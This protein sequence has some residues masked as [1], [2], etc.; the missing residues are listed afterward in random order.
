ML[1]P[2]FRG[3]KG[4]H[5]TPDYRGAPF[6]FAP[7]GR[8]PMSLFFALA[9]FAHWLWCVWLE[10]ASLPLRSRV[11]FVRFCHRFPR[12]LAWQDSFLDRLSGEVHSRRCRREWSAAFAAARAAATRPSL[13]GT[14]L[15]GRPSSADAEPASRRRARRRRVCVLRFAPNYIL[16]PARLTA[17]ESLPFCGHSGLRYGNASRAKPPPGVA[18]G[19]DSNPQ[20]YA[21]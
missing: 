16:V 21:R 4:A 20:R 13:A 10:S 5:Y 2:T 12:R 14:S 18:A 19:Y 1:A 3:K 15:R 17:C 7:K 8:C 11:R 6:F 9:S